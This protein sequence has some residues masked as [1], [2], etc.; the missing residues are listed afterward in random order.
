MGI[1]VIVEHRPEGNQ[2]HRLV[3][4]V[5][6]V[7]RRRHVVDQMVQDQEL[8]LCEWKKDQAPQS[9]LVDFGVRVRGEG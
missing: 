5:G 9:E 2:E 3:W 6:R 7:A 8:L 1:E 4:V